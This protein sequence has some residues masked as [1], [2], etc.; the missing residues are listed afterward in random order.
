MN[1]PLHIGIDD[2]DSIKAGCSTYIAAVLV[3]KLS[4]VATFLDYPNLIR[5]NPNVPWKTRGNAALSIRVSI[6]E[7]RIDPTIEDVIDIVEEMS[8][9]DSPRTDPGI[10]FLVGDVP[11]EFTS[12]ALR[13]IQDIV[14]IKEARD[15]IRCS[16]AEAVGFKSGRGI[17]GALAAVGETLSGDHTFEL[18]AYRTPDKRGQLRMVDTAS[19]FKMDK[20]LSGLTF[21]NIDYETNRVLL[22]PRGSDPVLLGIRGENPNAVKKAYKMIDI[23]EDVERWVIFRTNQGTD[24]HLRRIERIANIQHYRSVI[25]VGSVISV[26]H[27]I[28]GR[29]IIFSIEDE[30]GQIDCAAYEPTGRFRRVIGELIKGDKVEVHGG[31]RPESKKNPKTIN[32]EKIRIVTLVSTTSIKNPVCSVCGKHMESMGRGKGFRCKRCG[33]R[34]QDAEKVYIEAK[35]DIE[36]GFYI[37]PPR[38]NR[39]LTKPMLRYG[40]E[41]IGVSLIPRDFWGLNISSDR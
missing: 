10:V 7:K 26:P 39:H 41:K 21:N 4:K 18:I 6:N 33:L 8:Q 29:H 31:V 22:T 27:Y 1:F 32:L 5:L 30:S 15:L 24:A 16:G 2:T 36:E 19:I 14:S 3:E 20:E 34:A 38:A 23:R 17:I 13:T 37:P 9:M 11:L 28:S 12:F 35:R 40:L 25:V